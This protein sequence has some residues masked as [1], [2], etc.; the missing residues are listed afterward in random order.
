VLFFISLIP[1]VLAKTVIEY[2]NSKYDDIIVAMPKSENAKGYLVQVDDNINFMSPVI[3][4]KITAD[5]DRLVFRLKK[6]VKPYYWRYQTEEKDGSLGD[7]QNQLELRGMVPAEDK[8]FFM[9]GSYY[10]ISE[11]VRF[12]FYVRNDADL[13]NTYEYDISIRTDA[14]VDKEET[15]E[16]KDVIFGKVNLG[17]RSSKLIR[18]EMKTEDDLGVNKRY[19]AMA[20][21]ND[22][23]ANEDFYIIPSY[24]ADILTKEL[25]RGT[26]NKVKLYIT[27]TSDEALKTLKV[28][29]S[30][31]HNLRIEKWWDD[32]GV[33]ALESGEVEYFE[34]EVVVLELG[35]SE[36]DFDVFSDGGT[37]RLQ[38]IFMPYSG[39]LVAKE[40]PDINIPINEISELRVRIANTSDVPNADNVELVIAGGGEME[41]K[42]EVP[43]KNQKIN[44]GPGS[45]D[46]AIDF[47]DNCSGELVWKLIGRE[48]GTYEYYLRSGG[49]DIKPAFSEIVKSG[50]IN[51]KESVSDLDMT[52]NGEIDSETRTSSKGPF[53][54]D[55]MINNRSSSD[56]FVKIG[57]I[58]EGKGWYVHFYDDKE[59]QSGDEFTVEIGA[60]SSRSFRL[61]LNPYSTDP[62]SIGKSVTNPFEVRMSA[63][64]TIDADNRD[65]VRISAKIE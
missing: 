13:P 27:N 20:K 39:A 31:S 44:A 65:E 59:L 5:K 6:M 28:N 2:N 54:Y 11:P 9:E 10:K 62:G 30:T 58:S 33:T 16:V 25:E 45:S 49:Y 26:G 46:C 15:I 36:V 7:W 4:R 50:K 64:S 14:I 51:V 3:E 52:I 17:P 53:Y 38:K 19:Y 22:Y 37:Q 29:M 34:W 32:K 18:T 47:A 24:R 61:V 8:L 35:K 55:I 41:N 42:I 56:D 23:S 43:E 21:V 40:I 1:A 57:I 48:I 12:Y 63:I 60:E